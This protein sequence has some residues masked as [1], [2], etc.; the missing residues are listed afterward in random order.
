MADLAGS[1]FAYADPYSNTGYL[2]PR[3][4]IRQIG[5]DPASFFRKTF[6]T[7]SHRKVIVAVTEGLADGGSIDSFVWDTLSVIDPE[8]VE[9][10]DFCNTDVEIDQ[11]DVDRHMF[12]QVAADRQHAEWQV[13]RRQVVVATI[14]LQV[15]AGVGRRIDEGFEGDVHR[16]DQQNPDRSLRVAGW[17]LKLRRGI[18]CIHVGFLL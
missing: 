18:Q 4:E 3:Y 13:G 1:I 6:F 5:R 17:P 16:H 14:L 2:A 7:W 8:L 11:L 10:V 9:S 12:L 15:A